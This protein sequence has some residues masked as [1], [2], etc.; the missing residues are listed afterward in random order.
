MCNAENLPLK[1]RRR[2]DPTQACL[3]VN[4]GGNPH[5]CTSGGN[6]CLYVVRMSR[7][8]TCSLLDRYELAID[9]IVAACDG[10]VHGALRALMLVNEQLE[11][12]LERISSQFD[13]Q[14]EDHPPKE[15]LH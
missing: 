15:F 8:R 3:P 2:N 11:R 10:D 14:P 5:N 13:D 7:S 1:L 9:E 12:R 4:C 6:F